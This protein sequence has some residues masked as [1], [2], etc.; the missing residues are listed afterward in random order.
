MYLLGYIPENNSLYLG[1][2]ELNV[3]SFGLQLS[4][5]EY[6]TGEKFNSILSISW[7]KKNC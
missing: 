2:K 1:D 5:L 6:Q 7:T 3:V 4:V